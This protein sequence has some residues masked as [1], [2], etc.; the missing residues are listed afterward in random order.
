M[1]RLTDLPDMT[2][3]SLAV[4]HGCKTST[5]QQQQIS[6]NKK[7]VKFHWIPVEYGCPLEFHLNSSINFA[8]LCFGPRL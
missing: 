7:T 4:Y 6:N 2:F 1:V 3:L 5:Q 8:V